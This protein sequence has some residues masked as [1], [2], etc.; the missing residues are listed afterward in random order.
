MPNTNTTGNKPNLIAYV[1]RDTENG[2][3][4][5]RIGAA[6]SHTKSG[7]F[8]AQLQALPIDGKIVF[9]PPKEKPEGTELPAE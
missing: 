3:F 7:G 5:T 8:T 6:W 4:W 9:L 2:T 1:V